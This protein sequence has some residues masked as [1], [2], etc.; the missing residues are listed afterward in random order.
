[1]TRR[2]TKPPFKAQQAK[3]G[4]IMN[5][6]LIVTCMSTHCC[7]KWSHL[8]THEPQVFTSCHNFPTG[9]CPHQGL[10]NNR[11]KSHFRRH[12]LAVATGY[13]AVGSIEVEEK[14]QFPSCHIA[15]C[16][17]VKK[18]FV[19]SSYL[20]SWARKCPLLRD[21]METSKVVSVMLA[22][23]SYYRSVRSTLAFS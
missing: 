23:H 19:V 4:T 13:D 1:M 16:C 8:L 18:Q 5:S 22:T 2:A 10:A 14:G 20:L 6:Y 11:N 7:S 21:E 9:T 3:H 17:P 12:S 15:L